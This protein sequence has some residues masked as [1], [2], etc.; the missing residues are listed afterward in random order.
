MKSKLLFVFTFFCCMEGFGQ[1]KCGNPKIDREAMS[2]A[3]ANPVTGRAVSAMVRVYFHIVKNDDGTNAAASLTQIQQEFQQLQTD[4]APNN[5]CFAF[6][7]VDSINNTFLNNVM[8][9]DDP[10]HYNIMGAFNVPNCINIYYVFNLPNYGGNA[11]QIPNNFCVVDRSNINLW[12][13]VSHEVGHCMGLIHTFETAVGLENIN[14]DNCASAGD[15]VCDTPADPYSYVG[16][17][18]FSNNNC[19]YTG[20]CADGNGATNFLPPYNNIMS[21]WGG[22]SCN[23]TSFTNGQNNRVNIFLTSAPILLTTLSTYD[24]TY[25]PVTLNSGSSMQSAVNSL[26][27]NGA[28]QFG[29]SVRATLQARAVRLNNG[30]RAAPSSG[31]VIIKG[32][33][34]NY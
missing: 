21:Y 7:G 23:I 17:P 27:S 28:V 13:T 24:L 14:G 30:F 25:G 18:C 31:K 4:F 19:M 3:E 16:Q 20:S 1:K 9:S 12:R 6:M 10:A 2:L 5:I 15:R 26:N 33:G 22:Q 11:F 29:G 8:N 32:A 34:C